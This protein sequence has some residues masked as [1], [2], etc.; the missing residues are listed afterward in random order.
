MIALAKRYQVNPF[1]IW[2]MQSARKERLASGRTDWSGLAVPP[3]DVS[4][5]QWDL[6]CDATKLQADEKLLDSQSEIRR[7][8]DAARASRK[9][10]MPVALAL[11]CLGTVPLLWYFL[12]R[13][14]AELRA[15]VAGNP[16]D[17]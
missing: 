10:P 11:V 2:E 4:A 5:I 12:L 15:A 3:W 1:D 16:P 6:M 13:R 9:W 8:Y 7:A 14:I 17:R